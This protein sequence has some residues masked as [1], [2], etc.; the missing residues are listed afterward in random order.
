M[1]RLPDY[2]SA[3]LVLTILVGIVVFVIIWFWPA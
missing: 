3:V 1:A 2:W